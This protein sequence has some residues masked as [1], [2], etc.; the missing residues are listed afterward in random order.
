M[1]ARVRRVVGTDSCC[2]ATWNSSARTDPSA[3]LRYPRPGIEGRLFVDE[4]RQHRIGVAKVAARLET[5][6]QMDQAQTP[7]DHLE[8]TPPPLLRRSA[9]ALPMSSDPRV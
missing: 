5:G 4:P 7:E 6:H 1:R 9:A 3:Q 8:T 2:P